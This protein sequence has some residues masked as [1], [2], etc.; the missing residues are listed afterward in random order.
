V[1]RTGAWQK[2]VVKYFGEAAVDMLK[3]AESPR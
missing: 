3:Q 2:F 1:R